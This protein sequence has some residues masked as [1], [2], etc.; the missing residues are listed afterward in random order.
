[1]AD[2]DFY[3]K[4]KDTIAQATSRLADVEKELEKAYERWEILEDS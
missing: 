1:M 3:Q 4:D 2:A